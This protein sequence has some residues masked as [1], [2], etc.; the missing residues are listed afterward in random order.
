MVL[1]ETDKQK[2]ADYL[3]NVKVTLLFFKSDSPD[4][5]YCGVIEELLNDIK[6]ISE[7]DF[8]TLDLDSPLAKKHGIKKAPAIIFEKYPNIRY[9]GI[10]SGHEFMAFLSIVKMA[11]IGKVELP[12]DVQAE[13]ITIDKP[14]DI[15][16]FITPTCPYCKGPVVIGHMLAMLNP[17]ITSIMVEAMEY[18]ELAMKHQ[19]S[20]VPKIVVNGKASAEGAIPPKA[21]LQ[22]IQKAL[23][24]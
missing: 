23:A 24:E 22:L 14:V 20:A 19:V 6:E 21:M 8:R 1:E 2:V 16:V 13:A 18:R 9:Y 11:S 10:P 12:E 17:K 15:M 3:K 5:E 7:V 4:C